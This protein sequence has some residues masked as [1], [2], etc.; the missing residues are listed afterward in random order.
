MEIQKFLQ[1]PNGLAKTFN[2]RYYMPKVKILFSPVF[3]I[4]RFRK[5]G[6]Y[7]RFQTG[8]PRPFLRYTLKRNVPNVYALLQVGVRSLLFCYTSGNFDWEL[9]KSWQQKRV[10][11]KF[12]FCLWNV[13]IALW[14]GKMYAL[15]VNCNKENAFSLAST[16]LLFTMTL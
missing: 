11:K 9:A 6:N 8:L 10:E 16:L 4:N 12:N 5:S 2:L 13:I 14:T 7:C 15:L 3:R 1:I